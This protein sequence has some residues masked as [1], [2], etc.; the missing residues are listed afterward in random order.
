MWRNE[1]CHI[2]QIKISRRIFKNKL[3]IVDI[4]TFKNA[5]YKYNN[6]TNDTYFYKHFGKYLLEI[7]NNSRSND[8]YTP[9][10]KLIFGAAAND[11]FY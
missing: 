11:V 5:V 3:D 4:I 2:D 9:H 7:Y 1:Y 10:G 8:L 6:K